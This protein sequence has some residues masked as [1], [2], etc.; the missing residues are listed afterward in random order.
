MS[1]PKKDRLHWAA[2]EPQTANNSELFLALA[3]EIDRTIAEHGSS[4]SGASLGTMLASDLAYS[5]RSA[6]PAV[7][8]AIA[9]EEDK[10]GTACADLELFYDGEM[11]AAQADAFRRHLVECDDCSRG[12]A[13]LLNLDAMGRRYLSASRR[14]RWWTAGAVTVAGILVALGAWLLLG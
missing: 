8:A 10:F 6:W 11:T 5:T 9:R 2:K 7:R 13:D 4:A 1:E 3:E 12:L 14:R